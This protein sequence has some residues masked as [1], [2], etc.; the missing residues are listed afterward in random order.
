MRCLI[1]V[2]VMKIENLKKKLTYCALILAVVVIMYV[3]SIP[4]LFKALLGIEC[5]GCGMT[6]AYISL[7]RLDFRQA[8]AYNR[9]FWAVPICGL[10]YLFDGKL[11]PNKWVNWVV[12]YGIYLLIF[13]NWILF[14]L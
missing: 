11:F 1:S 6:R 12:E 8:F 13:V 14:K 10:F 4:C 3:F 9:M 2:V 5:P 7:F